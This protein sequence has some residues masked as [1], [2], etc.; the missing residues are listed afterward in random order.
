LKKGGASL[1]GSAVG[2]GPI[3]ALYSVLKTLTG[4]DVHLKHCKVNSIIAGK[5]AF[6]RVNLQIEYDGKTYTGRAMDTDILK[7]SALA[8]L[9]GI[10]LKSGYAGRKI[11]SIMPLS[12]ASAANAFL[13]K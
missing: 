13:V 8:F 2:D 11:N 4:R 7:A 1:K 12:Q 5:G 6:G 3:D 10:K 9:N